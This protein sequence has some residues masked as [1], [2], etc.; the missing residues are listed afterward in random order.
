MANFTPIRLEERKSL[1]YLRVKSW[2]GEDWC[3]MAHYRFPCAN[4]LGKF[5][6]TEALNFVN[7]PMKY[8]NLLTAS[9]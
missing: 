1:L 6:F 4:K 2:V 7:V 8:P 9:G 5:C 3:G